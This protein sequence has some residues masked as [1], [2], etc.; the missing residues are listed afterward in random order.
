MRIKFHQDVLF[1]ECAGRWRGW[2]S[3]RVHQLLKA[4]AVAI[5]ARHRPALRAG[6]PNRKGHRAGIG[7]LVEP[8][9]PLVARI[10]QK[11]DDVPVVG[12]A[13]S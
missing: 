6:I 11:R 10:D 9:V 1:A 5:Y 2:T 12:C 13:E 4:I 3:D 7:A 8:T